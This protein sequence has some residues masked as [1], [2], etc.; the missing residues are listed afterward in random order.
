MRLEF[1]CIWKLLEKH[2]MIICTSKNTEKYSHTNSYEY[3]KDL[4]KYDVC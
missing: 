3:F 1:L 2:Y 4:Q